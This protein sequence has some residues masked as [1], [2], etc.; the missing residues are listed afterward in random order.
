M[1]FPERGEEIGKYFGIKGPAVSEVMHPIPPS[2]RGGGTGDCDRASKRG[3][4]EIKLMLL[5]TALFPTYEI[6]Q[7][8]NYVPSLF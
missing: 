2:F 5:S 8:L 6:N 7:Q 4:S 3:S 1:F